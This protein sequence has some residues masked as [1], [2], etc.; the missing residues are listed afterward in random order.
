M[1]YK[2]MLFTTPQILFCFSNA[3]SGQTIFDDWFI[4]MFNVFLTT[5][6]L[7]IRA[8]FDK[9]VYYKEWYK[10]SYGSGLMLKY[11]PLV[12]AYYPYLYTTQGKK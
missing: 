10:S 8:I 9:D 2:N 6:P 11:M 7:A 3:Y 4:S 12:K 1:F 5:V